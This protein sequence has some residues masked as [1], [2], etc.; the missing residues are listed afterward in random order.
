MYFMCDVVHLFVITNFANPTGKWFVMQD[1]WTTLFKHSSFTLA[2]ACFLC[3]C[4]FLMQH[5]TKVLHSSVFVCTT[6]F[7]ST[8]VVSR[9]AYNILANAMLHKELQFSPNRNYCVVVNLCETDELYIV[10]KILEALMWFCYQF[11]ES[12]HG[13]NKRYHH[14]VW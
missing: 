13:M 8:S 9:H 4:K 14:F 11:L 5:C 12:I 6:I 2:I 1:L 3:D 7:C 10:D